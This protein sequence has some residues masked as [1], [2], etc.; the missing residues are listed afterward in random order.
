MNE[1]TINLVNAIKSG[2]AIST[3]QAFA[4]AMADKLSSKIEDLRVNIA[5]SMFAQ[6]EEELATEEFT[7][8]EEDWESLSEEEKSQ[9]EIIEEGIVDAAGRVIKKVAQ[10][11]GK[12]VGGV[13][14]TAGAIRQTPAAIGAAYNKGRA[15]AH[16]AIAEE[17]DLEEGIHDIVTGSKGHDNTSG[18]ST[19]P[20]DTGYTTAKPKM[21]IK[22]KKGVLSRPAP[23]PRPKSDSVMN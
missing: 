4:A 18:P 7:I 6:G 22:D 17:E 10:T 19:K 20:N 2:D 16:K 21:S 5:Q 14:K 15:G 8:T 12:V 11:A 13:A 3:E 1:N 23:Q 9:Y